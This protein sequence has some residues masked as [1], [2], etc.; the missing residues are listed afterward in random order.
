MG[1]ADIFLTTQR[2]A[3][4][5]G[6]DWINVWHG[7]AMTAS[8]DGQYIQLQ[9]SGGPALRLNLPDI[10]Y[11]YVML[12]WLAFDQILQPPEGS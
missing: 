5:Q 12:Y 11:F 10:H 2:V 6:K 4:N 1:G 7:D 8:C 9:R 3:L